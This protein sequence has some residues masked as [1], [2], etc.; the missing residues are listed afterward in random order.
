MRVALPNAW[1]ADGISPNGVHAVEP[2]TF[3]FPA[4]YPLRAPTIYLRRDFDRSLAHVQPGSL[5]DPPEPCIVDGRLSELLQ[6]RGL[7]GIVDQLSLWLENAALGR[8]IDPAQGWEPVR[9]DSLDDI[10]VAGAAHL[11]AQV[12]KQTGRAIYR[13]DYLRYQS[14]D[15]APACYGEISSETLKLNPKTIGKLFRETDL[16]GRDDAAPGRSVGIVVWPGKDPSGRQVVADVYR[17]ETVVDIGSLKERAAAYGCVEPL[18][19]AFSWLEQCLAGRRAEWPCPVAIVLCARR[20][21]PLIGSDSPI[22]L[23]PYVV[24]IGAPMLFPAGDKTSVRPAGHRDTIAMPLLRR[25]SGLDPAAMVSPWVLLGAGSL[26]SK[27]GLHLARA[28]QA[29]SAVIDRAYLSPHNSARH[30]L[31]PAPGRLQASWL[32][33]KAM[34]LVE[35]IKGLGQ[36]AEAHI[37]DVVTLVRD[38]V[39]RRAAVPKR[40]GALVN[41]TASL[42][43]REALAAALEPGLLPRVIE[44]SLFSA[45]RVGLVA[46]EGPD[47]N[48]DTGDLITEAYA[49]MREEPAL[50]SLVLQADGA[51][52]RH[53]IGE[54]CG[55]AT[56]AISDAR[57]SMMA[58]PMAESISMMLRNGLPAE[59]GRLQIGVLGEDG[60]SIA[61]CNHAIRATAVVSVD[62]APGWTVR[63]GARAHRK[64]IDEVV[65]WPKVETGGIV[66]GR[67]S[68]AA[69][70]FYV[71]D[72]L[73][74]PLDSRRSADEFVLGTEGVRA[75]IA[76]HVDATGGSLYC[77]GTWHSHLAASG[78]SSQDRATAVAVGLARLAPSVLLIHTPAGY[79]A[80]LADASA[81]EATVGAEVPRNGVVGADEATRRNG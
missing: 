60:M 5:E 2:V 8:L 54:G 28:G 47:R 56:M 17:P 14:A 66:V 20:P 48:P 57:I 42:V 77:L 13:F 45:G 76:A 12:T 4:M 23:C 70:T 43:T 9:R 31:T 49:I 50:A 78:P 46:V 64:I 36:S 38:P 40:T 33:A 51:V 81:R 73:S 55:S 69:R 27:I 79:R 35:A 61:W 18:N 63:V 41:A 80:L 24:E 58:A 25:L 16:A 62:D 3:I 32:G 6:Q 37:E 29:P 67:L 74:A 68:E 34:A 75:A 21:F 15:G 71:V 26:G 7:F 22:E 1:N 10:I 30:A 53:T 59:V 65:R 19:Q 39:R 11:R 44:T 52:A 72:V